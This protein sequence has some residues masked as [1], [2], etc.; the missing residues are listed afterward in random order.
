MMT[1]EEHFRSHRPDGRHVCTMAAQM[2]MF[3]D[4]KQELALPEKL[5]RQTF[6]EWRGKVQRKHT[7]LL[8][9]PGFTPQP[10]PVMLSCVQ[11]DGY[12]VEKWEF[13]PDDYTAVP[14]LALIPDE[15]SKTH[16]VPGVMCLLGSNHS[17]EFI[18][19]EEE[20]DHPNCKGQVRFPDRNRMAVHLVK[21]GM[22][23][24]A[25]DNPGIGETSVLTDPAFGQTQGNTRVQ[26]CHGYLD[27]GLNYP[28]ITVFHK[29]C[30]MKHLERLEYIDQE[31]IGISSF[32]LGTE[33]A[34]GLGLMCDNIRAIVF[35]EF[36]HND[37]R[38]YVAITE[39]EENNMIQNI[40]NWHI[41]PGRLRYFGFPELCAALAPKYLAM[42]E[43]GP[44]EFLNIV[45][46]AYAVCDAEDRLQISY[47]PAFADPASR[48][49][50]DDIPDHGLTREEF[51]T[52]YSYCLP[53]DHSFRAEPAI[54]L[55]KKA[56]GME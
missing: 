10:D 30:F 49:V 17:K 38:R 21:N 42:T 36:L 40:G 8:S 7:E 12:R 41:I 9:L 26:M 14:F 31:R 23:A 3:R 15:A 22:A 6:E 43:G 44:D 27:M 48:T 33:A 47:Y 25:F 56:F 1:Y 39:Q 53:P 18:C 32:S 11:R 55:L 52:K 37:L 4:M 13:Y 20:I 51:Y 19:G 28:G 34:L 35:N 50:H 24:F 54:K 16:P 45:K 29:L 2:A 46:R 5:D